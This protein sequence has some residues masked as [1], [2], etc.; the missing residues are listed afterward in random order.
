MLRQ[1]I[2]YLLLGFTSIKYG[3][4]EAGSKRE[5][6]SKKEYKNSKPELFTVLHIRM[7]AY[8]H[9]GPFDLVHG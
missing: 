2:Q 6:K 4:M 8:W 5:K 3:Q 1:L 9:M 7:G